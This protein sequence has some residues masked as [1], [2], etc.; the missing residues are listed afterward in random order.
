MKTC[1]GPLTLTAKRKGVCIVEQS[2]IEPEK[3]FRHAEGYPAILRLQVPTKSMLFKWVE[4]DEK[5]VSK[6]YNR[7]THNNNMVSSRTTIFEVQ[8]AIQPHK[9]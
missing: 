1:K 2:N 7:V 5:T 9:S 6:R 3:V 8:L 4:A